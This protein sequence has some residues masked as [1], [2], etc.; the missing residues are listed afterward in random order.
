MVDNEYNTNIYRS[1][2]VSIVIVMRNLHMLKFVP[3]HPKTEKICKLAVK[4]L[5]F[6]IRYVP[7]QYN[8]QQM[9]LKAIVKVVEH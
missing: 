6:L 7:Y 2:I 8:T 3:H 9:F 5:H 4:K 1:L